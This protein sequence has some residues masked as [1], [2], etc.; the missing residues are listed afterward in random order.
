RASAI[1][2]GRGPRSILSRLA[3]AASNRPRACRSWPSNSALSKS[4]SNWPGSTRSPSRT[5]TRLN[6]PPTFDP[7]LMLLAFS[8]PDALKRSERWLV[9]ANDTLKLPMASTATIR[10]SFFLIN[11]SSLS[12]NV[13]LNPGRKTY[14][15][16]TSQRTTVHYSK[17][18]RQRNIPADPFLALSKLLLLLH[19]RS[20]HHDAECA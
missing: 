18:V 19:V 3:R 8:V 20:S 10:A 6:R 12:H 9:H 17:N 4:T 1:S 11:A 2:S 16:L 14:E 7:S 13:G 5:T 15:P